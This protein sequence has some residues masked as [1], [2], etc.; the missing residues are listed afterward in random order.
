MNLISKSFVAC[1]LLLLSFSLWGQT[2]QIE[3]TE[4][5]HDY[6]MIEEIAGPVSHTFIVKNVG[7]APLVIRRVLASCGCSRPEWTRT[8]IEP[9]QKGEISVS[10]NPENMSGPFYK[11]LNVFSNAK[12]KRVTLYLEGSIIPKPKLSA[13]SFTEEIGGLQLTSSQVD[14]G[15]LMPVKEVEQRVYVKNASDEYFVIKPEKVPSYLTVNVLPDTVLP[16]KLGE[17]RFVFNPAKVGSKGHVQGT[18]QL[19]VEGGK[20][21]QAQG[22]VNFSASITDDFSSMTAEQKNNAPKAEITP[23]LL[24]V[25]PLAEAKGFLGIGKKKYLTVDIT[26][27]GKS[28]LKIYSITT[29][30]GLVIVPTGIQQIDPTETWKMKITPV[31][32]KKKDQ[33]RTMITLVTNDPN[34]PVRVIEVKH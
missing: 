25:S 14:F 15:T 4:Y 11:T 17:V 31:K 29:D 13:S 2:P 26:N 20:S 8:P 34:A 10:F 9:G 21:S 6:G 27:Y 5:A 32:T 24:D 12:D 23:T 1:S 18:V 33:F 19:S 16:E 3:P 28:A 30:N 22:S 7:D